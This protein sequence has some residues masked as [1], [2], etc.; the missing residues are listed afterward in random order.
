MKHSGITKYDSKAKSVQEKADQSGKSMKKKRSRNSPWLI[1]KNLPPRNRPEIDPLYEIVY[2][3]PC[4]ACGL[5]RCGGK[6]GDSPPICRE[7]QKQ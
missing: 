3:T 7:L 1:V 4:M 2:R 5:K 6:L